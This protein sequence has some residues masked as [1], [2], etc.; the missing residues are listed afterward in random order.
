M[1]VVVAFSG[2]GVNGAED[3]L[4]ASRVV[5]PSKGVVIGRVTVVARLGVMDV[6]IDAVSRTP[7][8]E[9]VRPSGRYD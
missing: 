2:M 6:E 3:P 9:V 8:K 7:A 5:P 1:S 4:L